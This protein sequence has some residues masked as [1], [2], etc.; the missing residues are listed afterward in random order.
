MTVVK[1]STVYQ[2]GEEYEVLLQQKQLTSLIFICRHSALRQ[3]ATGLDNVGPFRSLWPATGI[4]LLFNLT[5]I[6]NI[7]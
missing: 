6:L 3:I 2:Q 5:L 7:K 4:V 1:Q